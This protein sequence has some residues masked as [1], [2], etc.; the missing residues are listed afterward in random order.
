[1]YSR[2]AIFYLISLTMGGVSPILAWAL[3]MLNGKRH[4]AGWRW[5][6]VRSDASS[7]LVILTPH[8]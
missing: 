1:M 2:M 7:E 6:F 8:F 5:I 4:I 3:S